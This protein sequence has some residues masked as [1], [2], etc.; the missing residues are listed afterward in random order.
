LEITEHQRGPIERACEKGGLGHFSLRTPWPGPFFSGLNSPRAVSRAAA[1]AATTAAAFFLDFDDVFALV[2]FLVFGL[3]AAR[4]GD[5]VFAPGCLFH[6][7]S[8]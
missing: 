3:T 6:D 4:F 8:L 1:P 7:S 5:L 2:A